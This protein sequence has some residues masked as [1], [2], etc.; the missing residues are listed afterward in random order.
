MRGLGYD[1]R[2]ERLAFALFVAIV[3]SLGAFVQAIAI[4]GP[5]LDADAFQMLHGPAIGVYGALLVACARPTRALLWS[6]VV[7]GLGLTYL[8]WL[9][10]AS[11]ALSAAG[12]M[13][14]AGSGKRAALLGVTG[15]VLGAAIT[16]GAWRA[17]VA[18]A[19]AAAVCVAAL[20]PVVGVP[21][22]LGFHEV[23]GGALVLHLGFAWTLFV[24]TALRTWQIVPEFAAC[25]ACGYS[26]RGLPEKVCP[27]CG[28]RA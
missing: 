23:G 25:P 2:D 4:R 18:V 8:L 9:A 27:E 5:S 22:W 26:L 28:T 16:A 14:A 20:M 12:L 24:A 19:L 13:P 10:G 3:V 11:A 7:F 15:V 1:W 6:P 17:W 21:R